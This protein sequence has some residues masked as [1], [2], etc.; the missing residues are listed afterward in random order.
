MSIGNI[1][2]N[3]V[4]LTGLFFASFSISAADYYFE[5]EDAS[6]TPNF[7]PFSVLSDDPLA[8]GGQYVMNTG[9]DLSTPSDS[10]T[11]Q[12]H[13]NFTVN[14]TCN[15]SFFVRCGGRQEW[16]G[17]NNSLHYKIEGLDT[18]WTTNNDLNRV[19]FDWHYFGV[20]TAVPA[21][22][23]TLKILRYED[24]TKL[25]AFFVNFFTEPL[26]RNEPGFL[27]VPESGHI[28]R[29]TEIW[30]SR[31]VEAEEYLGNSVFSPLSVLTDSTA[32]GG[33][34]ITYASGATDDT[35]ADADTGQAWYAFN[36]DTEKNVDVWVRAKLVGVDNDSFWYKLKGADASWIK[37][38]SA[39]TDWCWYKLGTYTNL[40]RGTRI[41]KLLK[42]E[43]GV[44]LTGCFSRLTAVSRKV[45]GRTIL[46]PRQKK[47]RRIFHRWLSSPMTLYPVDMVISCMVPGRPIRLPTMPIPDR[48]II[49]YGSSSTM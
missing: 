32:S 1:Y 12:M 34:C 8:S 7:S 21:G 6:G 18:A 17:Y 16:A 30:P 35:P 40:A 14:S 20:R 29:L 47:I 5:A 31:Y 33:K 3:C 49:P 19:N 39:N 25:D 27:R 23:Y 45:P 41:L 22:S 24:G 26:L 42:C 2:K 37:L 28:S 46:R 44:W 10:A 11:G 13:F 38:E 36:L 9:A 43:D 48:R 15:V 4:I